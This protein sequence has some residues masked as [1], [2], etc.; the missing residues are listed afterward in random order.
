MPFRSVIKF[1]TRLC[2]INLV[3]GTFPILSFLSK[4]HVKIPHTSYGQ[5]TVAGFLL[6]K[7]YI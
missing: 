3:N 6:K 5:N 1:L 7:I 2:Y 4:I